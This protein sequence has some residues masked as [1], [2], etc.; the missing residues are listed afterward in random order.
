MPGE[1]PQNDLKFHINNKI[2]IIL[3]ISKEQLSERSNLFRGLF[4]NCEFAPNQA[5][6][7]RLERPEKFSILLHYLETGIMS[8]ELTNS[9]TFASFIN[10]I[11][12]LGIE[13]LE[14]HMMNIFINTVD[15]A[16]ADS[17]DLSQSRPNYGFM[18]QFMQFAS[19]VG[20]KNSVSWKVQRDMQLCILIINWIGDNEVDSEQI[21]NLTQYI[22]FSELTMENIYVLE[23]AYPQKFCDILQS[24]VSVS[25]QIVEIED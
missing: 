22:D 13:K 15:E 24:Y 11:I 8:E 4:E 20:S 2:I 25:P 14:T 18:L 5:I 12:Y 1:I 3:N 7:L 9:I 21:Q 17:I 10:D 23:K 16:K 6:K 19:S